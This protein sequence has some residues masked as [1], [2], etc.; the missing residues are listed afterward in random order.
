M[1]AVTGGEHQVPSLHPLFVGK[2][3]FRKPGEAAGNQNQY[4]DW[5]QD[6]YAD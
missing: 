4:A 2:A 5:N 3:H 6:Q 1:E